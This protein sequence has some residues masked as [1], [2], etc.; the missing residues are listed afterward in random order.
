MPDIPLKLRPICLQRETRRRP[1]A[2]SIGGEGTHQR[3]LEVNRSK[4]FDP[5]WNKVGTPPPAQVVTG[6]GE[7]AGQHSIPKTL[8]IWAAAVE[9]AEA[10]ELNALIEALATDSDARL[11]VEPRLNHTQ[12]CLADR[13]YVADVDFGLEQVRDGEV[14]AERVLRQLAI[15]LLRPARSAA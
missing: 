7:R 3:R 1:R 5:G 14:L 4:T 9:A 6:D 2:N 11:E 13:Q 10:A 8:E 15:Q 12:Q